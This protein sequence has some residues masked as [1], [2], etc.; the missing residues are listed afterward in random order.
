M[1]G[2]A[3]PR[4]HFLVAL[5]S[6]HS[7][8]WDLVHCFLDTSPVWAL[9]LENFNE[10]NLNVTYILW[11][12]AGKSLSWIQYKT[13]R[14]YPSKHA[15]KDNSDDYSSPT[16]KKSITAFSLRSRHANTDTCRE[17]KCRAKIFL[18]FFKFHLNVIP[19]KVII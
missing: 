14:S 19:E 16:H 11:S 6:G 18:S 7:V 10:E 1:R 13:E 5:N 2:H 15:S 9:S 12:R 3:L 17:S 8:K 4:G